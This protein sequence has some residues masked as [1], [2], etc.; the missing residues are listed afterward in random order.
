MKRAKVFLSRRNVLTLL[1]K[2][3]RK[4]AGEETACA[5]IKNDN[6][7]P[8]YPQTMPHCVVK[9]DESEQW[10][11]SDHSTDEVCLSRS[12]LEWLNS[13]LPPGAS[14]STFLISIN[15]DN[16]K[17]IDVTVVNDDVYYAHR[18]AG[19]VHPSDTPDRSEYSSPFQ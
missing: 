15:A 5:L 14:T 18:S 19:A 13:S 2:L 10:F 9:A 16:G 6:V 4:A 1:S 17:A 8:V 3:A 11:E 7:H 12:S